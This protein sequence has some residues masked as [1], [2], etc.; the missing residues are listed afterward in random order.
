MNPFDTFLLGVIFIESA[1]AAIFFVKFWK[2]TRD[3]L[4]LAFSAFFLVEAV[5]RV[6]L[7]FSNK[8]NEGSSWIH[9]VRFAALVFLVAMIV[10]KNYGGRSRSD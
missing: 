10:R 3:I 4:F 1:V 2:T 8:P 6:A 9:I 5:D 7:L